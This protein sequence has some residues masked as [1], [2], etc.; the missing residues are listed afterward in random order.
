MQNIQNRFNQYQVDLNSKFNNLLRE[1]EQKVDS[2]IKDVQAKTDTNIK[3]ISQKKDEALKIV[4]VISN[5]GVTGNYQKN[6][7]YHRNQANL[8]RIIALSSMAISISWL[9]FTIIGMSKNSYDWHIS[10]IRILATLIFIYPA[11]YSAKESSEHRRLE[12]IYR[13]MELDLAT[14]NPFIELLDDQTKKQIKEKL[15][16]RYFNINVEV[17]KENNIPISLLEKI[18]NQIANFIKRSNKL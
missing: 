17:L 8:F 15:V 13:K 11:Q 6:A 18:F 3:F 14:I 7:D 16:D 10:L 12:N 1:I 9:V 5:I 4:N 2:Y